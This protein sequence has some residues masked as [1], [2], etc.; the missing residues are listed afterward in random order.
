MCT[1]FF[2]N[3]FGAFQVLNDDEQRQR[4]DQF[5]EA[6]INM[7]AA[8]AQGF[9]VRSSPPPSPFPTSVLSFPRYTKLVHPPHDDLF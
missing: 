5:G 8:G 6:G 2:C 9:D 3:V 4:Y 1:D 7:G